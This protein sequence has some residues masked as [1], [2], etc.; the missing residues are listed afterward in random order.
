MKDALLLI[1][2]RVMSILVLACLSIQSCKKEETGSNCP[3]GY[4]GADCTEQ[5]TPTILIKSV[6]VSGIPD[7]HF[8]P[9]WDWDEPSSGLAPDIYIVIIRNGVTVFSS[10]DQVKTDATGNVTIPVNVS[11]TDLS[12]EY[13]FLCY[14]ADD[15]SDTQIGS[16]Q[17]VI[18]TTTN[19]FP[20]QVTLG[21]SNCA[22]PVTFQLSLSYIH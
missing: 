21:C 4:R 22:D 13:L 14:D 17:R 11:V 3:E 10:I 9:A 16:K 2:T 18:Y 7:T 6:T 12:S 19:G 1:S 15:F 5:I 20:A 8:G